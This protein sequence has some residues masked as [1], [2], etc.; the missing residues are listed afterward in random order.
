LI[1]LAKQNKKG[2]IIF[3]EG[4]KESDSMKFRVLLAGLLIAAS[5]T[6]AMAAGPYIGVSGGV[7]IFHDS[8]I[9]ADGLGNIATVSYDTGGAV[10]VNAGYDFGTG[11]IEAEWGYK[12][13]DVDHVDPSGLRRNSGLTNLD[14]TIKSYMVNGY[15][16][17]RNPSRFTP[18]IGAGIGL[19]DGDFGGENMSEFGYQFM[20][21]VGFKADPHVTF[22]LSYRYQGASDFTRDGVS[23]SYGSS[24]ILAGIRYNF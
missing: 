17:F 19:L 21:G 3:N 14:V 4:I 20:A 16:D 22:D 7:S 6:Q 18:F 9:S 2:H 24:N 1:L 11:R 12:T 10:N 15:Y 13:A 5:A 23:T 8:D